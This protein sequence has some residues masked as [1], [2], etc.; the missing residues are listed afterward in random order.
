ML[1]TSNH[2]SGAQLEKGGIFQ[3]LNTLF[4]F[5]WKLNTLRGTSTA[6][7]VTEE[8]GGPAA[9]LP[10][11]IQRRKVKRLVSH[12]TPP[13]RSSGDKAWAFLKAFPLCPYL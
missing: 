9:S 11:L 6:A 8:E 13:S 12:R 1:G 4:F 3:K 7:A 2:A 5:F 10:A